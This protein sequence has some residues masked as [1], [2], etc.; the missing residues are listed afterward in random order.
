MK[1]PASVILSIQHL[2][3]GRFPP[4][5][6]LKSHTMFTFRLMFAGILYLQL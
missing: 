4:G 2:Y 1:L 3:F 6:C 5:L